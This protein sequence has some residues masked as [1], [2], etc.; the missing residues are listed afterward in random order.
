M[1][2]QCSAARFTHHI[3]NPFKK[4]ATELEAGFLKERKKLV[5]LYTLLRIILFIP[6][7]YCCLLAQDTLDN[8]YEAYMHYQVEQGYINQWSNEA[9]LTY[10]FVILPVLFFAQ[11]RLFSALLAVWYCQAV[12]GG[13]LAWS[14]V[15]ALMNNLPWG[16][17]FDQIDVTIILFYLL[18]Y[19]VFRV[20]RKLVDCDEKTQQQLFSNAE[21]ILTDLWETTL[22]KL[23]EYWQAL[24]EQH[25]RLVDNLEHLSLKSWLGCTSA[26]GMPA[27]SEQHFFSLLAVRLS[28]IEKLPAHRLAL[29]TSID[30][31]GRRYAH[32]QAG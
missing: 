26:G 11:F 14:Y 13:L 28:M 30:Y 2:A 4:K 9:V 25:Q 18:I 27:V 1:L 7:V 10:G 3:L 16:Y 19:I 20:A 23:R 5:C 6:S 24:L 31:G 15:F 21:G 17:R 8:S 32:A 12:F 22:E 29:T